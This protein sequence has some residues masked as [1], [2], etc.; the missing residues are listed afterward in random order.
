MGFWFTDNGDGIILCFG[1][2]WWGQI[3]VD[4]IS[5]KMSFTQGIDAIAALVMELYDLSM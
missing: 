3:D 4:H 1:D 5:Y 2:V